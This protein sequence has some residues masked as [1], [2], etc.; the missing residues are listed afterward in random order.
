MLRGKIYRRRAG[1]PRLAGAGNT[2]GKRPVADCTGHGPG[3][4]TPRGNLTRKTVA[5]GR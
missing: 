4:G 1:P 5:F 2:D 3:P